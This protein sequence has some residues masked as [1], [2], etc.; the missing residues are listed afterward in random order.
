MI[1]TK[2]NLKGR[3]LMVL[4]ILLVGALIGTAVG[5]AMFVQGEGAPSTASG[6]GSIVVESNYVIFKDASGY[7]CA[8]NT[9]TQ[10]IEI[11]ETNAGLA[12]QK[13]VDR[14]ARGN[15]Y[16]KSGTYDM[17]R[18]VYTWST[19]ITGDGNG[20]ILKVTS[21]LYDSVLKVTNDYYKADGTLA[22]PKAQ[23]SA[24]HPTGVTISN[25]QV[26]GNKAVRSSGQVMRCVNF[27]DAINCQVRNI[28]AHDVSAGQGVYMT[29]S[30][31]CTVRD[32]VFYNIGGTAFADYGTGIAFGEASPTKVASSHILIDNCKI[33]KASMSSIDMEPA[34]NVTITNSLFL[35]ATTWNGYATPVIT[36]YAIK[37]YDRPNDHIMVSGNSVYG[38]FGEFII[39]TPCNYSIVSNNIVTYTA[40]NTAAIYS[41]GAHDNKITGNIIKTW[42]K[43]AIVGVNCNSYLI[44]DNTII[45]GKNSKSNYGIR[46]YATSGTSYYNI[47][48]GNQIS[49]FNYAICEI[50]GT[51]HLIVTANIIKS[52][53]VG[54]Y[55]KGTDIMRTGNV[56]NGA[57]DL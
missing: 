9:T 43:D 29:N 50:T 24:N 2:L 8:R 40:G 39:L 6:P 56:L 41:T 22:I 27:Q 37:G 25:L 51:N 49:G 31:Y 1:E 26:D 33:T 47:V 36:S 46:L 16:I 20:T 12:M 23:Q 3:S 5:A 21:S 44:S 4:S 48:K 7:T 17:S 42:G 13:A 19:S 10:A 38:A 54:I 28:Y 57:S 30:H 35:G 11:R 32:S 45:D 18:P 55:L 15:I 14:S 34:N 52:C 53:N